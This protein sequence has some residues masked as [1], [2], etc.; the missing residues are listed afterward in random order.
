MGVQTS[1]AF[2]NSISAF[3]NAELSRSDRFAF[4]SDESTR[5]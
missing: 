2:S 5:L 3:D 4:F 1:L